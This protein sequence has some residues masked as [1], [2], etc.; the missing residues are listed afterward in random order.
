MQENTNKLVHSSRALFV[1]YFFNTH[2][3]IASIFIGGSVGELDPAYDYS[4]ISAR[5]RFR[6]GRAYCSNGIDARRAARRKVACEKRHRRKQC[7]NHSDRHRIVGSHPVEQ[8]GN[9]VREAE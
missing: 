8:R 3:L 5:S 9:E 1:D 4:S 7:H 2:T 6:L